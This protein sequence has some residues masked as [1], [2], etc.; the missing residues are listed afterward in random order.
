M[1]KKEEKKLMELHDGIVDWYNELSEE[2]KKEIG[3]LFIIGDVKTHCNREL[4]TPDGSILGFTI[5]QSL[6]E[7]PYLYETVKQAM[8][9]AET[10]G[11]DLEKTMLNGV[12]VLNTKNE[13]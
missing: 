7:T 10:H 6:L 4:I 13:A 3:L 11:A 1:N 12:D 9:F 2:R 8:R 5:A